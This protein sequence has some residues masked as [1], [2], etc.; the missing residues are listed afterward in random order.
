MFEE[1]K[2]TEQRRGRSK[3]GCMTEARSYEHRKVLL[4]TEVLL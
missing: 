1:G 3:G 4:V 2:L